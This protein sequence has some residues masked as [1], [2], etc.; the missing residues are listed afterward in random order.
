MTADPRAALTA[1]FS[2][3]ERHLEAA[4]SRRGA[5]D[6]T[7][8]AAYQDLADA[9]E[10]YDDLLL[11]VYGEMTPLELYS[12]DDDEGDE[13]DDD[14]GDENDDGDEGD[15]GD[16]DYGLNDEDEDDRYVGFSGDDDDDL[17]YGDDE[18]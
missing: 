17:D 1:L 3:F 15:D 18:E 16:E 8:M 12:G 14:D 7:V 4:A 6:P 10:T 11:D 5:D 9:F 13:N 2:A